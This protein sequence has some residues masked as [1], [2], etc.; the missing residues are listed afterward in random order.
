MFVVHGDHTWAIGSECLV[1]MVADF[2]F[3]A[4][5]CI[6]NIF[7]AVAPYPFFC[8]RRQVILVKK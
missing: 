7:S 3:L 4:A 1:W 2:I 6:K 8:Y 5:I